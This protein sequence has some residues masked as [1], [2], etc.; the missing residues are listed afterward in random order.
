M[1]NLGQNNTILQTLRN[2]IPFKLAVSFIF[3]IS[4]NLLPFP[5][6]V[7]TARFTTKIVLWKQYCFTK[8]E[9]RLAKTRKRSDAIFST[10][11]GC[12]KRKKW[13]NS[14]G[15]Y[16]RFTL[17]PNT[18]NIHNRKFY[19]TDFTDSCHFQSWFDNGRFIFIFHFLI[20]H[21]YYNLVGNLR[22][23]V[24]S[25]RFYPLLKMVCDFYVSNKIL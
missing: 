6:F 2:I 21:I 10:R 17:I 23:P 13:H 5:L 19:V 16:Y 24:A 22:F 12:L 20:L 15:Y 3:R 7:Y 18:V 11:W 1:F 8:E 9:F 4:N 25:V 14:P